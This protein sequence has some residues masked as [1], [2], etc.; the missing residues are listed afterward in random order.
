M[1]YKMFL[2][3]ERVPNFLGLKGYDYPSK[4]NWVIVRS[5]QAAIDYIMENGIPFFIAFDHD[6]EDAHYDGKEGHE[7]TGYEFA[8]W[9]WDYVLDNNIVL[10]D[11][12]G[13]VVHSMNPTG[14][15]NIRRYMANYM[16]HY[17][18]EK[19]GTV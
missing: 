4:G 15:E 16:H 18:G 14:A 17:L 6:L 12:F 8:K 9:F 7:R 13:W 10:P 3:D 11:D 5:M 2:D 1:T 19:R